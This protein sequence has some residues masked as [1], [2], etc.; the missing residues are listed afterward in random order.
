MPGHLYWDA[1]AYGTIS[2]G[3]DGGTVIKIVTDSTD[4]YT[5]ADLTSFFLS[6]GL[7][8]VTVASAPSCRG[9][10]YPRSASVLF[11]RKIGKRFPFFKFLILV[12]D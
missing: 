11:Q 1:S 12:H 5:G 6:L 4:S 10:A 3:A 2:G 8:S 7:L 9:T